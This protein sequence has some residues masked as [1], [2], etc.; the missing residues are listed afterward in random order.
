M[1]KNFTLFAAFMLLFFSSRAQ[2]GL[3]IQS[4]TTFYISSGTSLSVDGLVL[5]PSSGFTIAAPNS[6]VKNTTITNPGSGQ[7][8]SRVYKWISTVNGFNG[9]ITIYY[10]DA[11]L[12]S[13]PEASLVLANNDGSHWTPFVSGVT[14]DAT[15]NFVTTSGLG[16]INMNEATLTNKSAALPLVWGTISAQRNLSQGFI[17]WNTFDEVNVA[18]FDVQSSTNGVDWKYVT[19]L[20]AHN[21]QGNN[22]YSAQD[23]SLTEAKTY[24]R[25]KEIDIDRK[26]AYS[27]VAI[28]EALN[29]KTSISIYPNP[30]SNVVNVQIL[31][32]RVSLSEIRLYNADGQLL[33]S[34]KASNSTQYKLNIAGLPNGQYLLQAILSDGSIIKQQITKQ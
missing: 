23:A 17:E 3:N 32:N 8:I 33:K 12:N 15:A 31:S 18:Q 28:V 13:I 9:D 20:T 1:N 6:L 11:E 26:F 14:S 24:Y 30:A 4:G 7:Y 22:H 21:T 16:S 29:G 19:S 10:Q 5:T 34:G 2:S 27:P 25:I